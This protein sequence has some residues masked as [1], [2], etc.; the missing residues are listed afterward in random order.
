[1]TA[2]ID[3]PVAEPSADIAAGARIGAGTRVWHQAQVADDVEIGTGCTLGKSCYIGSGARIGDNV[4]IGN[5]ADVFGARLDDG[6]M[7]SPHAVLTEDRVPR[8]TRP[9]GLRQGPG[10]WTSI[11]VIVRRGATVG[12]GARI[13]PGV[14][15]GRYALVGLGAVVVRDVAPH[16]LVLGNPARACGWV[17]RCAATLDGQLRC[18]RCDRAYELVTD[19]LTEIQTDP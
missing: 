8:A 4:K 6:V 11:P 12:A 9:D 13:A 1:M 10:D 17:C 14:E 2:H 5:H 3:R 7:I 15:I 18:P 16:A 19:L